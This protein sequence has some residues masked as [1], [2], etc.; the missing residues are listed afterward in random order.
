[1]G[2]KCDF[3]FTL[4]SCVL[5]LADMGSDIWLLYHY[6][7]GGDMYWFWFTLGAVLVPSVFLNLAS[8]A[9]YRDEHLSQGQWT[10]RITVAILQL[11]TAY[12][13]GKL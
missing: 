6:S 12:R 11:S 5:Y 8:V 7:T 10:I 9:L 1:M 13:Y 2:A 3:V 4:I